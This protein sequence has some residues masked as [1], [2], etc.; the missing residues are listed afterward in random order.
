MSVRI[1]Q[2]IERQIIGAFLESVIGAGHDVTV[3]NGEEFT[4]KNSTIPAD[5]MRELMTTDQDNLFINARFD[6]FGGLSGLLGEVA[7]IYGN[8]G[9]DV[10]NDYHTK[11][12]PF[13]TAAEAL[14]DY[15]DNDGPWIDPPVLYD[16]PARAPEVAET[17]K[18]LEFPDVQ[19]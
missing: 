4:L 12:E 8:S 2:F 17:L 5:I 14:A 9:Y 11:L 6:G 7:L 3:Y 19:V 13:M 18:G 15:W 1:R 10:I 16:F